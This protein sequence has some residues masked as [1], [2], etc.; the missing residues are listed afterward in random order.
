MDVEATL[1]T[2]TARLRLV[3]YRFTRPPQSAMRMENTIRVELALTPRH[4]S[5]RGCFEDYWHPRRF[6]PIGEIFVL[7]PTVTMLARSDEAASFT[8]VV[9][10]LALVPALELFDRAP[11]PLDGKLLLAGLDVRCGKVRSL[12]LRLAEEVRRPGFASKLLIESVSTQLQIELFRFGTTGNTPRGRGGLASWQ[13]RLIEE[14]LMQ[15]HEAPTLAELATLC[16]ISV[17]QL[18][19]AFRASQGTNL[20]SYVAERQMRHA[21]RLLGDGH[22]VA[23]TATLLG[24]SSASNFSFAFRRALGITPGRFRKALRH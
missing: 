12:L 7:P 18:S 19:R 24:F 8:S 17:R 14:R 23:E 16:R 4:R 2:S 20:G 1:G 11:P 21:R 22:S 13:L 9:C 5:A 15:V 6:E 3:R 10:E